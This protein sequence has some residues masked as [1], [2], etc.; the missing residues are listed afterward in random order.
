MITRLQARNMTNEQVFSIVKKACSKYDTEVIKAKYNPKDLS[1]Y[2]LVKEVKM[3]GAVN[4]DIDS[5][6]IGVYDFDFNLIS[7]TRIELKDEP[8]C[9]ATIVTSNIEN[10]KALTDMMSGEEFVWQ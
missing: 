3:L 9:P 1:L 4:C 10:Y 5:V 2:V 6:L 8:F 7:D